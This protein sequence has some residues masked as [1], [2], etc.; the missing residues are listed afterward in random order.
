MKGM[1]H[2]DLFTGIAGFAYAVDQV[3]PG[4]E[5]IFCDN[6]P[7]CRQVIKK[8]WPNSKIY[9][10]IREI[11]TTPN[12]PSRGC[13][14]RKVSIRSGRSHEATC[15]PI[16]SVD[17]ITGGFP[18]QPF[19]QAGKR[20]GTE[21]NRYLW[22]E[23]F[24]VIRLTK[25]KWVIAENVSGLI[26]QERGVVLESICLNLESEGY[27]V[28]SFIIPACAIDAPHRRDRVWIIANRTRGRSGRRSSKECGIQSGKL[29]PEK[30][31]RDP[32]RNQSE[33]CDSDARDSI[34]ERSE[35]RGQLRDSPGKGT[36]ATTAWEQNWIE[37]ATKLCG[38][39]A[40]FPDWLDSNMNDVVEWKY[41]QNKTDIQKAL[42][43]LFRTI[44][45]EE[46]RQKIGGLW[47]V[48]ET[49]ILLETM[50]QF[51]KRI[52]KQKRI[53]LSSKG[54]Q[55]IEVRVLPDYS[56]AGCSPQRRRHNEQLAKKLTNI[57]PK[58]PHEIALAIVE[59]GNILWEAYS[60]LYSQT[61]KLDGF[62]LSKSRHRIERLKALGNSI[63]PQ[64][65]IEIMKSI[66]Q[67]EIHD[68]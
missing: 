31:G 64:I 22:P 30:Q 43:I 13:E 10:D 58:L 55:K 41:D 1:V 7:F 26:S 51:Q 21:D 2:L 39:D 40:R 56:F 17:I 38:M 23:M 47:K 15:D 49:E 42:Q 6:D 19:S 12:A 57:V 27:T 3:W 66:K 65:A 63:V 46:I 48:D 68:H 60:T 20:K 5:H 36:F 35:R 14:G 67:Y 53:F 33:G 62:E 34:S 45:S 4:A 37:V 25:P 8:H 29:E 59:T 18:C 61:V 52:G 11:K 44:Q 54:T 24:R 32:A 9:D 50:C 16:G 28:Q